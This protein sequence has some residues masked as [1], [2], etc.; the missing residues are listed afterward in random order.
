MDYA[1]E[2]H[3]AD[4]AHGLIEATMEHYSRPGTIARHDVAL[5]GQSATRFTITLQ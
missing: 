3:L 5:N 4:L 2:R 1:S